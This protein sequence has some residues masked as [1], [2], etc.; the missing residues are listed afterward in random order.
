MGKR[1][2]TVALLVSFSLLGIFT[3]NVQGLKKDN[4]SNEI[5]YTL[6][7]VYDEKGDGWLYGFE[8]AYVKEDNSMN[9]IFDGYNLKTRP[10]DLEYYVS[11]IDE[12]GKEIQRI[13][14]KYATLSTSKKYRDDIK[15]INTFFNE[16]KFLGQISIEDLSDLN[17]DNI[18]KE[19][20]L[21]IFNKTI[22]SQMKTV[23]GKYLDAPSL[24]WK[25]QESTD[26][27]NP[28][29]WQ[30]MYFIDYGYIYDIKIEFIK[31]D[32]T[33]LS[34]QLSTKV[35]SKRDIE[36]LSEI[37]SIEN[38]I[39]KEQDVS[40]KLLDDNGILKNNDDLSKLLDSLKTDILE[41]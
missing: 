34:D 15:K 21:E 16:K 20:I 17:I 3:V 12:T 14:S 6:K 23:P 7:S 10:S 8:I 32:N 35:R 2:I 33:Y 26:M 11:Y 1:K 39:V 5:G 18:S 38:K 37:E 30:I 19:D 28:G 40:S 41:K 36:T 25:V 9:Y 31:K 22:N 29:E 13:P 24:E 4:I 27:N